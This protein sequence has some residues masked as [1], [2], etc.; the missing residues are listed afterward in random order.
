MTIR[1]HSSLVSFVEAR[2]ETEFGINMIGYEEKIGEI[3]R[4]HYAVIHLDHS[5]RISIVTDAIVSE[6]HIA[7]WS[8]T[9]QR[10][11][12][13]GLDIGAFQPT[14]EGIRLHDTEV[15]LWLNEA[16]AFWRTHAP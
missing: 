3:S 4:N 14:E 13:P 6:Q 2:L 7:L 10:D 9:D 11:H 1:S 16:V 12:Y 5:W 15:L 8:N